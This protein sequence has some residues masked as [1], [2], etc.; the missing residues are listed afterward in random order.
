MDLGEELGLWRGVGQLGGGFAM[1]N[2]FVLG[3]LI[4]LSKDMKKHKW[5][6]WKGYDIEEK[7]SC[8]ADGKRGK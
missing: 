7:T 4:C 2:S 1:E 8:P 6:C 5:I 3:F